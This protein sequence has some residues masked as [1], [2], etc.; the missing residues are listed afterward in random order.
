MNK[1]ILIITVLFLLASTACKDYLQLDPLD[2]ISSA[3]FWKTKADFD[4]GLTANYG[5]LQHEYWSDQEPNFD[6]MTDNG[7]GQHNYGSTKEIAQGVINAQT[8][9]FI[10]G[11][12]SNCYTSIARNNI[13][14]QQL[15]AYKGTDISAAQKTLYEAEVRFLRGYFYF[16]L[17]FFYGDVPLVLE[18]V[19]VETQNQ[20]KSTAAQV[21]TQVLADI[22]FA[23]ANLN[24]VAAGANNGHATKSAAQ[25]LKA[26]ILMYTAY[27]KTGTPDIATLTQARD[28]CLQV[29]PLYY[30]SPVFEN[31]FKDSGQK[32]NPE[33]IFSVNF[34]KPDSRSDYDLWYG[35]WIVI[36]P[37][38]NFVKAFE[39]SDGLDYGVSPLTNLT[40]P[41][42]NRD[43]RLNKTVFFDHPDWGGGNVHYP[44]NGRPTTFGLKK[45]LSPENT[46]Y[47]YTTMTQTNA[48]KFRLGE[49]L[50]M[51]AE[52]QNEIAGPDASVYKALTDIRARVTM[53]P[54]AA[55]LTQDQMR[56]K[57][58]KE[59]RIEL[60]FEEGLRYYDLK[61]WR[62]A[63]TV[64]NAVT[65]AD[66]LLAYKFVDKFYLWPLPQPE[67]DMSKGVLIQN[68]DYQ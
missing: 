63:G 61:R 27:G 9:G 21:L 5:L 7:Y 50:L 16:Q 53:P 32:G 57:I 23:I 66:G 43:P 31:I 10:P 19:T 58:R 1:H 45:Y 55:G 14:L 37:L 13:F 20:P 36:S 24:S 18:P 12:Y 35:D 44:T 3:T 26:R 38:G 2:Q 64:L 15:A 54:L 41:F 48:V 8:G 40:D 65:Q 49:I 56:E 67:I 25:A 6:C 11:I 29:A 33:I 68:P 51:Y 34:L 59:R 60:A 42:Q 39:C 4:M 62:T 17:Y 30:L 52:A 46:P 22:D 47:G 28:L